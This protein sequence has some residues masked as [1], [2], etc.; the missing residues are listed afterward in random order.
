LKKKITVFLKTFFIFLEISLYYRKNFDNNTMNEIKVMANDS[1]IRL[2]RFFQ[3]TFPQVPRAVRQKFFRKKKLVVFRDK[4]RQKLDTA[5]LLQAGDIVKIFFDIAEFGEKQRSQK[6]IN[7]DAVLKNQKLK[8]IKVVFEDEYFLVV[9][10]PAGVSVH[11]GSGVRFGHSLIDYCIA[12]VRT[13]NPEAPEPK[14]VHRLDKNTSGLVMV[15]K[16]DD[17]LRKLVQMM[18]DGKIEKKYLALVQGK[19]Q[20]KK[21]KIAEKILRT[22]GSKFQK[23]TIDNTLGKTSITH[24]EEKEYL[25]SLEATFVEVLLETGRMHQIRIHFSSQGHPLAGDPVY[26]DFEWNKI[27][28]KKYALKRQFLHAH[29][30]SFFHPETKKKLW[31]RSDISDDLKNVFI[32]TEK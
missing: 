26:G 25:P 17:V 21:G 4:K 27:L 13:K 31:I 32:F 3:K 19:L 16:R 14:L 5:F 15:A 11:P 24:Y 22:E 30:L 2:E 28:Q 12:L 7:F 23:I 9:E 6:N 18:Q 29:S 20:K 1:G 8:K 10:K